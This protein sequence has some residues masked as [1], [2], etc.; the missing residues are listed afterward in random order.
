MVDIVLRNGMSLH[1]PCIKKVKRNDSNQFC[2]TTNLFSIA[3]SYARRKGKLE[4]DELMLNNEAVKLLDDF[5]VTRLNVQLERYL[6]C[7]IKEVR[8]EKFK[9]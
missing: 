2:T 8:T 1:I 9:E 3:K 6:L 5:Y 7:T 4:C